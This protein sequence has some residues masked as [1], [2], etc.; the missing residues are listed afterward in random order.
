MDI[1]D[2]I[3]QSRE[4]YVN[5]LKHFY[6]ERRHGAKELLLELQLKQTVR[7]FNVYRIDY[8][9]KTNGEPILTDLN[10]EKYFDFNPIECIYED[11]LSN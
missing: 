6:K 10:S 7:Q 4:I 1:K 2:I 8:C 11:W 9:E 5:D 3:C